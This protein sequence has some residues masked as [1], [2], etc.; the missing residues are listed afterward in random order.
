[1]KAK[2]TSVSELNERKQVTVVFDILSGDETV[3]PNQ[4]LAGQPSV[5]PELIKTVIRDYEAEADKA[6]QLSVGQIIDVEE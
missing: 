2:I 6:A 3:A 4:S 1:M 5:V